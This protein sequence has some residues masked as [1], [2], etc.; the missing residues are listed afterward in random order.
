MQQIGDRVSA[1]FEGSG[2]RVGQG[3]G[4]LDGRQLALQ[5]QVDP[6][7]QPVMQGRRQLQ[8]VAACT[9]LLGTCVW[10]TGTEA[11]PWV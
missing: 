4:Q 3:Q 10:P 5:F 6:L 2:M 11:T 8:W 1:Q 7:S 9:R